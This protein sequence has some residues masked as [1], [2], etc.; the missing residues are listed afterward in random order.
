MMMT[1]SVNEG[2]PIMAGIGTGGRHTVYG[3]LSQPTN[4]SCSASSKHL[5]AA[6]LIYLRQEVLELIEECSNDDE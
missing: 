6:D 1:I 2:E 4:A 3:V 5:Q